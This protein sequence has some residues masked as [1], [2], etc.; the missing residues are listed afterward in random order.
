MQQKK[1]TQ[2]SNA[3]TEVRQY[4]YTKHKKARPKMD[5]AFLLV[6]VL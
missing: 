4:P 6:C 3:S 1:W 5:T 2:L